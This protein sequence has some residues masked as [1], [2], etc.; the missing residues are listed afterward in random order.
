MFRV[1]PYRIVEEGRPRRRGKETFD[2]LLERKTRDSDPTIR[3]TIVFVEEFV[4]N[5]ANSRLLANGTTNGPFVQI[6]PVQVF[7]RTL[8]SK[9]SMHSTRGTITIIRPPSIL[10]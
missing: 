5:S 6:Q 7:R 10:M 1:S 2:Q 8:D 4:N 3:T 9:H